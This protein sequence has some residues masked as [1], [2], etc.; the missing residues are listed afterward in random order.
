MISLEELKTRVMKPGKDQVLFFAFAGMAAVIAFFILKH[1]HLPPAFRYLAG[2]LMSLAVLAA[3]FWKAEGVLYLL[4]AYIPFA[5]QMPGDFDGKIPGVNLTNFLVLF[6]AVLWLAGRFGEG[7]RKLRKAPLNTP[8]LIFL[9]WGVLSVI[10]GLPYGFSYLAQAFSQFFYSWGIGFF[11][12]FLVLNVAKKS[13]QRQLIV[14]ILIFSTTLAGLMAAY[15]Y[16]DTGERAGGIF[17]HANLLASFFCYYL[18]IPLSFFLFQVKSVQGW[19]YLASFLILVRGVMVS[20][21]RGGYLAIAVGGMVVTFFRS[22]ILFFLMVGAILVAVI[23]PDVLPHGVRWRL[24]QTLE[25]T[26]DYAVKQGQAAVHLDRSTS[27]RFEL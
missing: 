15:E 23:H 22:K 10:Q 12:Y 11:L 7:T 8:I 13:E 17:D 9:G 6:S 16:M 20:F 24:S 18:F 5:K 27:D 26:P 14:N 2:F 19:V 21:S 3:G 25:K 1:L 4:V